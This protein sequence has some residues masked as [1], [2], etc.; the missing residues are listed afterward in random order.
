MNKIFE[1]SGDQEYRNF[2][3]ADTSNPKDDMLTKQEWINQMNEFD[4]HLT[5]SELEPEFNNAD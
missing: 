5:S 1:L 3:N 4:I 2:Y